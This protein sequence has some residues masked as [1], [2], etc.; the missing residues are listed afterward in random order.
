MLYLVSTPIGNLE[1][2]SLRALRILA[3]VDII[4]AEDTRR[5]GLLLK[6]FGIQNR[7]ESY[8][9]HNKARKSTF[10]LN[11]LGRG[12]SVA[13]VSD[14]GTP[15]ISDPA[16]DLV[17][18]AVQASLPVVPIPGATAAISGLTVSGLPTD[19]FV[20]EGFLPPKKGRKARLETLASETRTIILYEAPHRL[21]RTL[22][23]LLETMGD[24]TIA[25]CREL[26][27]KFE[28]VLRGSISE[29][30]NIFSHRKIRG[31]F[32]LIIQGS[33]KKR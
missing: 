21:L 11:Q 26:T 5:T 9:E 23:D 19:R 20:F 13:I 32:V 25:V 28:E 14:A 3:E 12:N 18:K 29:I 4:A 31:E 22:S 30:I 33:T 27:K 1:D 2:I 15:G 6:H 17:R 10:L 7:M 8:H 16:Y 24:R